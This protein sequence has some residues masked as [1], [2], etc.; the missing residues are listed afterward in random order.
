ME[1]LREGHRYLVKNFDKDMKMPTVQIIQFIE[2]VPVSEGSTELK[3]L[4]NGTTN[5]ELIEVLKDRLTYLNN[6]FPCEENEKAYAHLDDA[7]AWLNKRTENR[8]NRG[9]EGKAEK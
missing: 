7:L 5:E 6:K 4:Y 1:V 8:K 2:K 3:T 9:V